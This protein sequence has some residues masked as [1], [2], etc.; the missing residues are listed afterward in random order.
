M[1]ASRPDVV[2]A[3]ILV[4]DTIARPVD[5]LPEGGTLGLVG[6]ITLRA[7]GSALNTATVL[8]RLGLAVAVAGKVGDDAFGQF[9]LGVADARGLGRAG[10]SVD[11][12][13]ATSA[14]VV[15]V[16]SG[17]ERTFLHVPAA[18]G[19]LRVDELDP[20]VVYAGRVLHV[21][22]ALVM[23]SLD[24]E[25]TA[26]LFA[27]ARR[28]GI[29]TSMDTVW[30]PS[31]RWSRVLPCLP[32]LDVFAP[33]L[34]EAREISGRHEPAEVARWLRDAGVG[35]VALTMG[36]EGA[37][38]AEDGFAA[39]LPAYRVEAVD[40]TGSGDAFAAGLVYGVVSGW[41]LERT[42]RFA[43]ALG[44]LAVTAVGATEGV[45]TLAETLAFA[46]L[47]P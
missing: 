28:R 9:L 31:G 25:P 23:P 37:Y 5:E 30:D 33:S 42:G 19:R 13:T 10:I 8:A 4:A 17:G 20:A 44:A 1:S 43:N 40:G 41:P 32:Q 2:C 3:G 24:G 21:A 35:T 16:D 22:G 11:A 15:L 7:G 27:E 46:G 34:A 12:D 36:E 18:N 14:T 38:V 45:K 6:E 39:R 26:A 47:E 29:T